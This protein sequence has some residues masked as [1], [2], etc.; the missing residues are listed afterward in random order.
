MQILLEQHK[1]YPNHSN[2]KICEYMYIN[3]FRNSLA[4][5]R[6]QTKW[7]AVVS[8]KS[9]C[10]TLDFLYTTC[11]RHWNIWKWR[12][13]KHLLNQVS[14]SHFKH[15]FYF[16][17]HLKTQF[18]LRILLRRCYVASKPRDCGFE[19]HRRRNLFF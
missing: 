1:I 14:G 3:V 8:M 9:A 15:K 11:T 2:I 17:K 16:S 19:S 6:Y 12:L 7:S 13:K 18:S 10:V 5:P 4:T